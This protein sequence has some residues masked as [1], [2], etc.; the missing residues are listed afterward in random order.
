M[1][2]SYVNLNSVVYGRASAF[3]VTMKTKLFLST[4]ICL[5][6]SNPSF[7]DD[8][9]SCAKLLS[10]SYYTKAVPYCEKECNLNYGRSCY[11][12]GTLYFHGQGVRQNY[13]QA[14]T[15]SEKACNLNIGESCSDLGTLYYKGQGVRRNY[16]QT[17]TY[18]EKA[19][20]LNYGVGCYSLGALYF[21]GDGVR[22]NKRTAKEYFGKAC[23]LGQQSGCDLYRK[24]N[25]QGY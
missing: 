19:C 1:N 23:D 3:G 15:Y 10:R 2:I 11:N 18:S 9:L 8:A 17:K 13:Q 24:L 4:V 12:L 14:K 7:A 5:S 21:N 16:Q 6:L 20:N 22:R 25:E